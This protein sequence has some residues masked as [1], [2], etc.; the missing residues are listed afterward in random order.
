M[1]QHKRRRF[2]QK[3]FTKQT[4]ELERQIADEYMDIPPTTG[5]L[6]TILGIRPLLPK[7]L[8][9]NNAE[10]LEPHDE[11]LETD[12]ERLFKRSRIEES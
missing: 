3:G 7:I 9:D 5:I 6:M 4:E 10:C 1:K 12:I 11:K 2:G 8:A